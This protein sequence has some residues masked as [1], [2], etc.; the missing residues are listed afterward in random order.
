MSCKIAA[1][2]DRRRCDNF[3]HVQEKMGFGVISVTRSDWIKLGTHKISLAY[4]IQN[5]FT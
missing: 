2:L 1:D 5:G 3:D 4:L